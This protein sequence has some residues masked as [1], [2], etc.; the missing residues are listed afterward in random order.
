MDAYDRLVAIAELDEELVCQLNHGPYDK[1][2]H[3]AIDYLCI[4]LGHDNKVEQELMIPVCNE[5][6]EAIVSGEWVLVYCL[7]CHT[8][9]W[10]NRYLARRDYNGNVYVVEQCKECMR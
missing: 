7:T 2:P 9:G 5:C 10:I 8:T 6:M 4:G 3:L 1:V